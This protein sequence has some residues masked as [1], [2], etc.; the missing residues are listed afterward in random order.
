MDESVTM[1]ESIV[2]TSSLFKDDKKM[3]SDTFAYLPD[4][5]NPK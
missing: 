3:D 5:S 2:Q 4:I 1:T